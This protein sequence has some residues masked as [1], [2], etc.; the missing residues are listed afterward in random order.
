MVRIVRKK[1]EGGLVKE[2]LAE[3]E[4]SG[5]L[6]VLEGTWW[7][8]S[9]FKLKNLKNFSKF[10]S[11]LN[12]KL[13]ILRNIFSIFQNVLFLRFF[14]L[15]QPTSAGGVPDNRMSY[16]SDF[17]FCALSPPQEVYN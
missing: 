3:F 4:G 15:R 2:K 6:V 8:P 11:K 1:S 12:Q 9:T 14:S 17:S 10:P 16:L 5:D 7:Y 13:K